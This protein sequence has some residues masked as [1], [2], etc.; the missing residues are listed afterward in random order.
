MDKKEKFKGFLESLKGNGQDSLIEYVNQGF[1]VCFENNQQGKL[2]QWEEQDQN[3]RN[4]YN[5]FVKD[6]M[7]GDYNK[8]GPAWAKMHNRKVDDVFGDDARLKEFMNSKFNFNEFE[9][10]D[11]GRYWM[12]SQHA[13]KYIKFQKH[14]LEIIE[15]YLGNEHSHYKYLADR[16]S[17]KESGTQK[18]NTQDG[19]NKK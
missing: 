13:D 12:L 3:E 8:A 2:K 15:K 1:Q 7:A 5:K 19:C 9:K 17:C 10:E 6:K 11:W 4:T 14:A 18:Y 16:I